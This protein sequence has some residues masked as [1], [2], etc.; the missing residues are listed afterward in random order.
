MGH[1]YGSAAIR[2]IPTMQA[3]A[4]STRQRRREEGRGVLRLPGF[5]DVAATASASAGKYDHVPPWES[6]AAV[7]GK[8]DLTGEPD[9]DPDDIDL[10]TW[11]DEDHDH[12]GY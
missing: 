11:A 7:D 5:D 10:E 12:D 1:V 9:I 3:R 6:P 2:T 8:L 4:Q